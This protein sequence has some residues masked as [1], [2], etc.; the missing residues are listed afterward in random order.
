MFAILFPVCA[1]PIIGILAWSQIKA[2]RSGL[3]HS[4]NPYEAVQVRE[5]IAKVPLAKSLLV[6]SREMDLI[7]LILFTAGWTCVSLKSAHSLRC[8][9]LTTGFSSFSSP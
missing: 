7:G 4:T 3:V 8:S 9:R 5:N 1:I 6:W 2:R